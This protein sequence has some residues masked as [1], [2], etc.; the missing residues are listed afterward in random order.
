MDDITVYTGKNKKKGELSGGGSQ[1]NIVNNVNNK[2]NNKNCKKCKKYDVTFK[3]GLKVGNINV[4]GIVSSVNK[5]I[6][7]NN[8][9]ELN[10]LDVICIQQWYVPHNRQVSEIKDD[11]SDDYNRYDNFE[12]ERKNDTRHLSVA[13]DMTAFQRYDKIET[14]T[15]TLILYKRNLKVVRIDLL[16][17]ISDI[18]LDTTWIGI[19]TNKSIF[20]ICSVYHSPSYN[21]EYDEIVLQWNN[22]KNVCRHYNRITTIFAGDWN[23]KNELW[24]STITDNRGIN[25]ADWMVTNG[26]QFNNDG[27]HTYETERKKEVLDVTM[28]T[29]NEANWLKKWYVQSI[30]SK[31]DR[32]SDHIGIV[33]VI[34]SDPKVKIIPTRITWNLDEK[35]IARFLEV[36]EPKWWNGNKH[37]KFYIVINV[38]W[39]YW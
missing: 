35:K 24:G 21:C 15:K 26:L 23:S 12:D 14:N 20:L 25:L 2:D 22:L 38:M 11:E 10:D 37:I 13:L 34:N 9:I 28:I 5:R 6:E 18:G 39:N 29:Q 16:N 30:P 31:E 17:E 19:E 3:R 36:L 4:R 33:M 8:W 32:F 27:T 1:N 7:L